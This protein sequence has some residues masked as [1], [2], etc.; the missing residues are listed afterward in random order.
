MKDCYRR[1]QFDYRV[2]GSLVSWETVHLLVDKYDVMAK[3]T[4]MN[5][6]KLKNALRYVMA[7]LSTIEETLSLPL[8]PSDNRSKKHENFVNTF[9][10]SR[11]GR[12]EVQRLKRFHRG[13][14]AQK[15][16]GL[17]MNEEAASAGATAETSAP[18]EVTLGLVQMAMDDDQEANVSKAIAMV[19][20]ASGRGASIVCLPELFA[21]RYFPQEKGANPSAPSRYPGPPP[22]ASRRPR[23]PQMSPSSAAP[24]TRR[25]RAAAS[26][27]PPSSSTR[28]A[29]CSGK[30]R[31]V[32]VPQDESFYEKDYFSSGKGYSRLQDD[33]RRTWASSSASTSGTPSPRGCIKLM[34]ADV[35]FYPTAIGRVDGI[36]ETE[37]D[38]KE[39]WEA[40]Q[41]GHAIANSMVVAAVN[42]VG[43]EGRMMLLGWLVRLRPVRE[44]PRAEPTTGSRSSSPPCDL[45]LGRQ[46]EE[47]WG[48]LRNRK[49]ATYGKLTD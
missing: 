18:G 17:G 27:T 29:G 25:L 2:A 47:G 36:E 38:W 7:D 45:E 13:G 3:I 10:M 48:F 31:K 37:G 21:S 34:G 4:Q 24:S 12:R 23:G 41:R 30:Y 49:P 28:A 33:P 19:G 26:T 1:I 6:E 35:L 16:S 9:M 14:K 8:G 39:A 43:R 32:Q 40:V 22:S 5:K 44:G 15:M 20:E 42:R 46:V 11:D